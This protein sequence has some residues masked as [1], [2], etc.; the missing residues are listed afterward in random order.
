MATQIEEQLG[1]EQPELVFQFECV[2]RGQLM[3]REQEKLELLKRFR[4][5]VGPEVPW[6]GFTP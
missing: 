3:F 5:P 4:R 2:T 1:G 6:V